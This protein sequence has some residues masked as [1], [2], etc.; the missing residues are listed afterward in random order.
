[1]RAGSNIGSYDLL[2]TFGTGGTGTGLSG[3]Q[4]FCDEPC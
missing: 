4:P 1:M 3:Q 2:E